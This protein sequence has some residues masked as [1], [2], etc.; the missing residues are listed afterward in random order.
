MVAVSWMTIAWSMAAAACFTLAGVHL[1]VWSRSSKKP[2][3][4]LFALMA[5][6]AGLTG[7]SELFLLNTE[8]I[9]TYHSIIRWQHIPIF[10]LLVSM[11]WA[12]QLYFGNGRRWLA[13]M[14]TVSWIICLIINFVSPHSLVYGEI[15]SLDRVQTLGGEWF[16]IAKGTRNPWVTLADF[17]SLLIIIFVAD[18]SIRLWR[19]GGRRRAGIIGGS[20]LVFIVAAGVHAPLVDASVIQTPYMIGFAFLAIVGAMSYELGSD[21][22]R[23]AQLSRE[24][25]HNER[26]WRSLLE[27]V[28]LLVIGA[29]AEGRINYVNPYF[30]RITGRDSLEIMGQPAVE[31]V[32][33]DERE[34]LAERVSR[35]G[36]DGLRPQSTWSV[37]CADGDSRT[38]VFSNVR[39]ENPD[40]SLAGLLSVGEDVTDRLLA[41]ST[42]RHLAGRLINAQEEERS[43]VAR[44]LHDD[45]TQRL[46]CLSIDVA[47][48]QRAAVDSHFAASLKEMGEDLVRLSEDVHAI[49]YRLHPSVLEDLGLP[50]A[51]ASECERFT[52]RERIPCEIRNLELPDRIPNPAALGLFRVG[53]EALRN[54]GRH[55]R[56]TTVTVTLRTVDEGVQLAV[57]DDGVGFDPSIRRVKPSMGLASMRERISYLGGELD[58]ES[59]PGHGTTIVA[60]VPVGKGDEVS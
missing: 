1:V 55:A 52:R 4:L 5:V 39:L 8:S 14:I 23:A 16:I 17:T 6:G 36:N 42:A 56:A 22:V 19:R 59:S 47:R 43:R 13:W 54:I 53:Q 45:I 41:E 31:L 7:M 11:V 24:V 12:V 35:M 10:V 34:A 20:I 15:E 9:A 60:W 29:D 40:G 27:G 50:E 3:H 18:A 2:V 32:I 49:A 26:R 30:G 44:D 51:L 25:A 33:P 38:I 21:A 37:R 57:N 58:I 28:E 48:V 46:A